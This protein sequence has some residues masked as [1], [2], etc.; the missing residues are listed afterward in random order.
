MFTKQFAVNVY[1]SFIQ[2]HPRLEITQMSFYWEWIKNCY[3]H[4][5]K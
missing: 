3:I 2:N 5:M 1:D 4:T